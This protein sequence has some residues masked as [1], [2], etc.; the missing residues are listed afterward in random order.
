MSTLFLELWKPK[1]AWLEM[2]QDERADYIDGIGPSIEGLLEAGVELVGIGTV[3]PGTDLRADY[4]Y[5][6]VWRLPS[7]ELVDRFEQAVREDRFYDYFEQINA[8]GEA[9][10]PQSV[11][12]D[13]IR[14]AR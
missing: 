9:R 4:D 14:H 5:W 11:F 2:G 13:M 3:D 12:G 1:P 6:A 8:R 7:Q 10:D